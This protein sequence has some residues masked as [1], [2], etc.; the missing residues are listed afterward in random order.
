[1]PAPIEQLL[2]Q[3]VYDTDG[4]TTV[5]DFSFA[6]GYLDPSHVK[7]YTTDA[8]GARTPIVVTE[9]M[10][11]GE[12]Q[13]EITPA[14]ADNLVLT[15]YRETPKDAPLVNFT[16]E[17]GFSEIALD[18]NAKQAVFIAAEA[19]DLI[20]TSNVGAALTA[21]AL[22]AEA[23]NVAAAAADAAAIA[24][25]AAEGAADA[26][27]TSASNSAASAAASI[28][29]VGGVVSD[30]A[31]STG[32]TTVGADD[33][34]AGTLF[35]T[36]QGALS[37]LASKWTA[38]S[39]SIGASLVG[40]LP[41]GAGAVATNVQ[42]K[43]RESVSVKDFGA[44]GDGVTDDTA[45]IQAAIDAVHASGGGTVH[46][47]A[48]MTLKCTSRIFGKRGV[49]IKSESNSWLD[50]RGAGWL[51]PTND[52]S[53]F[54]YYGSAGAF[55]YP[56]VDM[57]AGSNKIT[58]P[59]AS[60]FS[61][62]DMVDLSMNSNGKWNDTSVSVTAGQLAIVTGVYTDM[63]SVVLSEPL[64]E[65]LTVANS[66]RIRIIDPI[67]N[68]TIDGLGIIGNGRNPSGNADQGLKVFFG[69]NV[70]IKNCRLQ[71][72][73]TQSIGVVSCYGAEIYGNRV[74]DVPLEEIDYISYGIVYSS[75]M[76]V[77]IHDNYGVNSRHGIVSS[78]LA[79]S[80]GYYGIN[81]FVEIY[82]NTHTSNYGDLGSAG[83][84]RAHAGISTHTDAEFIDIR[85]NTIVGCRFG[86]NTRTPN[87][88]IKRNRIDSCGVGIYFSE[89][90]ADTDASS[91]ILTNCTLAFYTDTAPYEVPRGSIDIVDNVITACGGSS[92]TYPLTGGSVLRIDGNVVRKPDVSGTTAI[93]SVYNNCDLSFVSNDIE[94]ADTFGLRAANT[95][96]PIISENIITET[97]ANTAAAIYVATATNFA[98]RNNVIARFAGNTSLP[99]ACPTKLTAPLSVV[100]GNQILG[101]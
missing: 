92:F 37:W 32:A 97:K 93:F 66:A 23:S 82:N 40:F 69:R 63:N 64:Y 98:I 21:A 58:V 88:T 43:L 80:Y 65:T 62:G 68:V 96:R 76:H 45:A 61:V 22:A 50:F 86:V 38:L 89:Y 99:L 27:S 78:H 84:V 55:I 35:T 57:V 2:S 95:G 7:A 52:L 11:I 85:D 75:S 42:S 77:K 100:S 87:N 24:A 30:L 16:D 19:A 9:P 71:A 44:V 18:T 59:D 67:E 72:V 33:G 91:N 1:M 36:V 101:A 25:I 17:S 4:T 83:F 3:T 20:N 28:E 13:L 41:A 5:W 81:R 46:I 70:K 8:I 73:D 14:L 47:P 39:S 48:S 60:V 6:S 51:T 53:L 90:W 94:Q 15:I 74:D 12:F 56:A 29:A 31:S 26:A 79:R 54:G 34:A 10:L 49:S